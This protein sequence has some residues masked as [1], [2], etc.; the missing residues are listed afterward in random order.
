MFELC[1]QA[2]PAPGATRSES[3]LISSHS[4]PRV[5]ELGVPRPPVY[6]LVVMRLPVKCIESYELRCY[7]VTESPPAGIA[8]QHT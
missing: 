3:V 4:E 7:R 5:E 2:L 8:L 1:L 6:K